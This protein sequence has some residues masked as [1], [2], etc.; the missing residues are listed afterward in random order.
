MC[1]VAHKL[2]IEI[3]EDGHLYY[4][5]DEIGQKLTENLGF[6]FI[7]ITPDPNPEAGFDP[8]VEIA[9]I[10]YYINESSVN[11]AV[12]SAEKSLKEKF[13]KYFLSYMSRFSGALKCIKYFVKKILTTL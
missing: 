12:N 2:V 10:Y 6:T 11:L 13:T 4:E 3:D 5:N 7:G 9:K 1:F 8:D